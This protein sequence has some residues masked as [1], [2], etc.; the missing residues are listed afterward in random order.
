MVSGWVVDYKPPDY[1][2][3]GIKTTADIKQARPSAIELLPLTK[4]ASNTQD[5]YVSNLQIRKT[6]NYRPLCE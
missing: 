1:T 6:I 4:I 3:Y 5:Y 2:E